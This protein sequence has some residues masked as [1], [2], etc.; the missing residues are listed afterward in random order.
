MGSVVG[1][2][3][4]DPG[5]VLLVVRS[6][7]WLSLCRKSAGTAQGRAQATTKEVSASV[8]STVPLA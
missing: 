8:R 4:W 6:S 2:V 7:V 5:I 3:V 1:S